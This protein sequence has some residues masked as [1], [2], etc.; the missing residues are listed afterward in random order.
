[1]QQIVSWSF[2]ALYARWSQ[3]STSEKRKRISF[4]GFSKKIST[5]LLNIYSKYC[6]MLSKYLHTV[7][8]SCFFFGLVFFLILPRGCHVHNFFIL[9]NYHFTDQ[10]LNKIWGDQKK[11]NFVLD[12]LERCVFL[13]GVQHVSNDIFEVFLDIA[14]FWLFLLY[15][16]GIFG[17]PKF[18]VVE[19]GTKLILPDRTGIWIDKNHTFSHCL[20]TMSE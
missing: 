4:Q 9:S 18:Q 13:H 11:V 14:N 15:F 1:M 8:I 10:N 20:C 17:K 16:M 19:N 6:E 3:L 12:Q 7:T 2:D 5:S